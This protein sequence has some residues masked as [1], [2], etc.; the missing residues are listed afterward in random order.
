MGLNQMR[1]IKILDTT[2]SSSSKVLAYSMDIYEKVKLAMQL[3]KLGV[4]VIEIGFA[5]NSKTDY[6]TIKAISKIISKTTICSLAKLNKND[7]DIAYDALKTANH[8]RINLVATVSNKPNN[9]ISKNELLRQIL[10]NVSYAKNKF[11]DIEFS[12]ENATISRLY[13]IYKK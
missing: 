2:L 9:T 12:L 13:K 3:E 6:E 4:D 7:I 11:N 1:Q 10:E 5:S 8:K